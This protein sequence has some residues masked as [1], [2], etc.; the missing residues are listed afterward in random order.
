MDTLD[1]AVGEGR[2]AQVRGREEIRV[3]KRRKSAIPR[4]DAA[5]VAL[6]EGWVM[7]PDANRTVYRALFPL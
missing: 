7:C 2:Q 5:L 1:G 4:W 6:T 3:G